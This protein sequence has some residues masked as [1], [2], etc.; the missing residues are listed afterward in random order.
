MLISNYQY[1]QY[2]TWG[3]KSIDLVYNT[4][5]TLFDGSIHGKRKLDYETSE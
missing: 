5:D 3:I 4:D 2:D 1:R